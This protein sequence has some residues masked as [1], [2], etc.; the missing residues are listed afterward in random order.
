MTKISQ[1]GCQNFVLESRFIS[2]SHDSFGPKFCKIVIHNQ[3]DT[4]VW[5]IIPIKIWNQTFAEKIAIKTHIDSDS[6]LE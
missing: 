2:M 4:G 3:P 6:S 5:P 1:K